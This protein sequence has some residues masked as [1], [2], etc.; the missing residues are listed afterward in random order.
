MFGIVSDADLASGEYHGD[1]AGRLSISGLRAY[2]LGAPR[3][4]LHYADVRSEVIL[5]TLAFSRKSTCNQ[6]MN[7]TPELKDT[8]LVAAAVDPV[9]H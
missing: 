8:G 3:V 7:L 9:G 6:V 5:G 1:G 4:Q 2:G